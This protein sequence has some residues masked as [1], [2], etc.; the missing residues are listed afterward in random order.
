MGKGVAD[1]NTTMA[2][3][4]D[5]A[6]KRQ[7]MKLELES[8]NIKNNQA[9]NWL[10]LTTGDSFDPVSPASNAMAAGAAVGDVGPTMG[11]AARMD[12]GVQP[13]NQVAQ[14]GGLPMIPGLSRELSKQFA[15]VSGPQEYFKKVVEASA[16]QTDIGKLMLAA[17]I[18]PLSKQGQSLLNTN[19]TKTNYVAP[20]S[21]RPGGYLQDV[22]GNLLQLPH[23]PDGYTSTQG[24]DG[25]FT[26]APVT[27]GL[28][29]ISNTEAA[30]KQGVN[31]QT[32]AVVYG[33][34]NQP[35]FSTVAQTI[36]AAKPPI[37]LGGGS[38]PPPGRAPL[39][40]QAQIYQQ[41]WTKLFANYRTAQAKGDAAGVTR[42][43]SDFNDLAREAQASG[44]D[45]RTFTEQGRGQTAA[46]ASVLRPQLPPGAEKGATLS[47]E[48]LETQGREMLVANAQTQ[49]V[50]SRLSNIKML[51]PG[52][53]T[54]TG[55]GSRDF[56]NGVL[57]LAGIGAAPDAKTASDLVDK[58]NAQITTAVRMGGAGGGS[59][60]L[61]TLLAAGNPN[62]KMSKEAVNEAVDQLMAAQDVVAARTKLLNPAYQ[63]RN[64]S[65][66]NNQ[67]VAFDSSADPRIWQ[68]MA[69]KDPVAKKAFASKLLQSDPTFPDKIKAL[70]SMGAFK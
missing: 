43:A 47:Q 51:I 1:M 50:K 16:P 64:P 60:A 58:N 38:Q 62:R 25:K 46:P 24:K 18:D 63:S 32:P 56:L 35:Q 6:M 8:A 26:I 70:E 66:F 15:S 44:I 3:A 42:A 11:N 13:T 59:D 55:T 49:T 67:A 41:E 19:I 69:I 65:Q 33:A 37:A 10:Q 61:Q 5:L 52:A 17:G 20:V 28:A 14:P 21:G 36:D 30:K 9:Q 57:A 27:G 53:I 4:Q 54:G 2:G 40:Q 45:P 68:W 39:E 12:A 48:G 31:Q 23:V 29:A 22:N 34:D 7:L